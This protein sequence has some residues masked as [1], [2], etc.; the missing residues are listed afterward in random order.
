MQAKQTDLAAAEAHASKLAQEL[1]QRQAESAAA[2]SAAEGQC[3]ELEA[4]VSQV[5]F[6][7]LLIKS[8]PECCSCPL[9]D[10]ACKNAAIRCL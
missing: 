1:E 8:L 4:A 3:R 5:S 2:V 7:H 6:S 10:H 9:S